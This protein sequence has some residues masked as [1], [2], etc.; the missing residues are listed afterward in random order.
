MEFIDKKNYH[1]LSKQYTD[2]EKRAWNSAES[3]YCGYCYDNL[4]F[5]IDIKRVLST[6]QDNKCC[7]CMGDINSGSTTLEHVYP[8][9]PSSGDNLENYGV[10]CIDTQNFDYNNRETP[11]NAGTNLPHDISYYNLV[12]SCDSKTSCNN[13]RGNQPIKPLFFDKDISSKIQYDK[14]GNMMSIEYE[15]EIE[16]LGLANSDLIKIRKLWYHCSQKFHQGNYN[17]DDIKSV[18]LELN[19]ANEDKFYLSF[20]NSNKNLGKTLRYSY[21]FDKYM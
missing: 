18:A 14:D 7:Y 13:K 15:T 2:F 6:E 10:T 11:E 8:Q 19:I 4:D 20:V 12:A 5:K 1:Q 16:I 3:R 17:E 9:K 21:F